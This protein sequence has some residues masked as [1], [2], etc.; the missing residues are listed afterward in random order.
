MAILPYVERLALTD[1]QA[2]RAAVLAILRELECPFVLC[3]EQIEDHYPENII[4]RL[5]HAAPRLVLGAHYDSVPGSTGANDNAASVAILLSLLR[6]YRAHPPRLP[7]DIV[8]F[9]LEEEGSW[10]S[11]AYVR[12]FAPERILAMINLDVCGVGNTI[13]I[14]PRKNIVDWPMQAAV[15][16]VEQQQAI[17]IRIVDQLPHGDEESFEAAGIPNL[18]VSILPHDDIP[19]LLE[20][21]PAMRHWQP[22]ARTPATLETIHNGPRDSIAVIEEAAMQA[23]L[24]WTHAVVHTLSNTSAA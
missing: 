5:G 7:C 9:D 13:L 17:P 15:Q 24:D 16:L 3:R 1:Q 4:V 14:G 11:R 22:P 21:V 18:S 12:R 19:L 10:G 23:V 2:R 20:A 6:A 8:F